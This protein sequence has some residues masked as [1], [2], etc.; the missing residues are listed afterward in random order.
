LQKWAE[1][2][3]ATVSKNV[4]IMNTNFDETNKDLAATKDW[5]SK[6]LEA[7]KA[8]AKGEF[9]KLFKAIGSK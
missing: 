2:S 3:N 5:V 7:T 4:D 6:N 1:S 9:D 8:W